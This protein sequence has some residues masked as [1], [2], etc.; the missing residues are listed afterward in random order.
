MGHV[1]LLIKFEVF[2][3]GPKLIGHIIG[4]SGD[5]EFR[6]TKE[7]E[8]KPRYRMTPSRV[9][10]HYFYLM[11]R[12]LHKCRVRSMIYSCKWFEKYKWFLEN[13]TSNTDFNR[14]MM[15]LSLGDSDVGDITM[16]LT[17]WLRQMENFDDIE[18]L[19][20]NEQW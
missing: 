19:S 15:H 2:L 5:N 20:V 16:L 9:Y 12:Y 17:L 6:K 14:C 3:K 18:Q 11:N 13:W 7:P 4:Q 10:F 1:W 8:T